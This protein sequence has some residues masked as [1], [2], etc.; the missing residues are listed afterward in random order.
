MAWAACLISLVDHQQLVKYNSTAIKTSWSGHTA[1]SS[2]DIWIVAYSGNTK[3]GSIT[4]PLTSCFTGLE[5]AVWQ[6]TIFLFLFAK[7]TDP[8]QSNRKSMIQWYF[9]LQ[10]SLAYSISLISP[11]RWR[12]RRNGA[13]NS[14]WSLCRKLWKVNQVTFLCKIWMK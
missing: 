10:C 12:R 3:G 4:V 8:N 14:N 5:S 9:P 13:A 11:R 2:K 7:Q 6:L 1:T